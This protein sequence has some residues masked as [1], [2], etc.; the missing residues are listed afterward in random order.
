M[1]YPALKGEGIPAYRQAGLRA[2]SFGGGGYSR[3]RN[4]KKDSS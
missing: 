2:S 4:K 1:N 3:R